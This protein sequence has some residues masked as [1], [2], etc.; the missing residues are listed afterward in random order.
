MT[1]E[2]L[3]FIEPAELKAKMEGGAALLVVDARNPDEFADGHIPGARNVPVTEMP[4]ELDQ[5]ASAKNALV[6][7]TCGSSGRGE[8]AAQ[9]MVESGFEHVAVLRGGLAAWRQ[10]GLPIEGEVAA[11][12]D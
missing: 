7:T 8:K 6:V 11:Q 4:S 2:S 5:I 1:N 10:A 3:E 12:D 9:V